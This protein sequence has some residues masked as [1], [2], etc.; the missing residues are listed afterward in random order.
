VGDPLRGYHVGWQ[1]E[2][3]EQDPL[4]GYSADW[5]TKKPVAPVAALRP[6]TTPIPP[7][8]EADFQA[9]ARQNQ[10][11]DLDHP[12]SHYDYRGAFLAGVSRGP[13]GHWPD[14]FKQHG[15]PTFSIE[16]QYAR[17]P[18]DAGH[19][20]GHRFVPAPA[21][22]TPRVRP[23]FPEYAEPPRYDP[24]TSEPLNEAARE[25]ELEEGAAR[26][27]AGE[28]G[29]QQ[30]RLDIESPRTRALGFGL[31]IG[32]GIAA[33][34]ALPFQAIKAV[35]ADLT[36]EE[37][38]NPLTLA[39]ATRYGPAAVEYV[40]SVAAQSQAP[41]PT[42]TEAFVQG[43]NPLPFLQRIGM[44][45][46]EALG[47]LGGMYLGGRAAGEAMRPRTGQE[48]VRG[49]EATAGAQ[50]AFRDLGLD[51]AT[52]TVDDVK[53]AFR[54]AA[55]RSH[56]DV[57]PA[58][59]TTHGGSAD[60]IVAV[61]EFVRLQAARDA[62]LE[63]LGQGPPAQA[64][65]PAP[66]AS[67]QPPEAKPTPP[68]APEQ[69]AVA[70]EERA[71]RGRRTKVPEGGPAPTA[72]P[73]APAAPAVVAPP[74]PI[75]RP[76]T[77]APEPPVPDLRAIENE[78]AQL[79]ALA[80]RTPEQNT[81]LQQLG[82]VLQ[83]QGTMMEPPPP[84]E[85]SGAGPAAR[86]PPVERRVEEYPVEIERRRAVAARGEAAAPAPAPGGAQ[87]GPIAPPAAPQEEEISRETAEP[88]YIPAGVQP[89]EGG[90]V[91]PAPRG[92]PAGKPARPLP[93]APT[94]RPAP[95][96][97]VER[98]AGG[99]AGPPE[100]SGLPAEAR[101]LPAIPA[102]EPAPI[103]E[104]PRGPGEGVGAARPG[105]GAVEGGPALHGERGPGRGSPYRIT[106]ADRLGAG[107]LLTKARDNVAAVRLLKQLA[108]EGRQ[109]SPEEQA[110]LVKYV[111]WGALPQAFNVSHAELGEVARELKDLLTP[112]EYE[113]A[114]A[115]TPNAHYT[116][117]VVVRSIY[118]GL[119]RMGLPTESRLLEPSA[120]V[121]HF[122]G[123]G[124][125]R[126]R[127]T[128]V[129]LDPT[130]VGILKQLYP[131]ADVR[132]GGFEEQALPQ[133]FYHAA[134][135]NVPFGDYSVH[136]PAYNKYA[137]PIHNYFVA[138]ML[139]H[140]RPGGVVAV[141]T[142]RYAMDSGKHTNWRRYI[143]DRADLLGAVRLPN[144]AFKANA[145]TEVVADILFLRR[146][147]EGER[148]AGESWV[149]SVPRDVGGVTVPRS[150]Y[151]SEHPEMVLGTEA[152]TGTQYRGEEYTVEPR[153]GED[154]AAAMKQAI[155]N[156]PE[157]VIDALPPQPTDQATARIASEEVGYR[158]EGGELQLHGQPV[159]GARVGQLKAMVRVRD[160]ARE[161]LRTQ[162]ED[163]PDASQV[164]ARK[165]LAAAYDP[166][167]RKYGPLN[168]TVK[169]GAGL[170][171]PNLEVFAEDPDV[172]LLAA[173][174][175]VNEEAGTYPKAAI[176]TERVIEKQPPIKADTPN[177]AL[178][179]VLNER[180]RV[181]MDRISDLLHQ[182]AEQVRE[183]LRGLIYEDPAGG[184]ETAD[185]YLSGNVRAKLKAAQAA[186]K[187]DPR[188]QENVKAL[189]Q[190]QPEDVPPSQIAASPG[191][192]WVPAD[193][194]VDFVEETLG[195][196]QYG[197]RVRVAYLP[198][199]AAWSVEAPYEVANSVV[200]RKEWGTQR[201]SAVRLIED[202]LNQ[203]AT[204][205]YDPGPEP[206][207]RIL[208]EKETIAARELQ[209][210]LRERF[211]E[212]VWKD[213]IRGKRLHRV[214]NDTYNNF[215]PARFDGSYL[216]L[217]GSSSAIKLLPHQKDAIWRGLQ[218][219]K[220]GLFQ[221]VGAGK[222]YEMAAM[223]M[224]AKRLGLTHKAMHVVP[225]HLVGQFQR[226][227]LK[228]YPAARLLVADD[229]TFAK[230]GAAARKEFTA[231]AATGN[232]DSIVITHSSF[233]RIPMSKQF[234]TG[235]IKEMLGQYVEAAREAKEGR[236]RDLTKL[237]EKG[238]KRLQARLKQ[239]ENREAKDDLLSF[240]HL[241]VDYLF[242]D[243]A[244][245][246]KNLYFMTKM[247]NV[248][249]AGQ[250]TQRSMDMY[251][252]SRYLDQ[253]G[254][255]L[256]LST[257]TP[258]SN[259]IS[260]MFTM[261]RY[262][263]PELLRERGIEHFDAWAA[264]F[265]EARTA[266]ELAPSGGGYRMNTRFAYFKN[267]GELAQLFRAMADVKL[268]EDLNLPIPKLR[269][270]KPQPVVVPGRPELK[271]YIEALVKRAAAI[272]ARQ[273]DPT[274]DNMLKITHDG[275]FAALDM[276][277]VDP[278]LDEGP[279]SKIAAV[280]E[281]VHRIW[282]EHAKDRATQLIFL[283]AVRPG[284]E[285]LDVYGE[286][287]RA[288]IARGIPAEEIAYVHDADTD[289]R[290]ETLFRRVREGRVR[291]MMGSIQKMG[292]GTN[293]QD[294]LLALH[295]VDAP[296]RP[297]DIEQ[298][299]GRILRRGNT[300][301][302]V[303]IYH[304]VTEGS[305]DSYIWQ[306]LERK[307]RSSDQMMKAEA[308]TRTI[309]DV[310][311]RALTFAE[312]KAISTGNP[313]VME[314]ASVDAEIQRLNRLA[315]S[316][317]D[318]QFQIRQDLAGM[319]DRQ[320]GLEKYI[321]NVAADQAKL[322]DVAGKAFTVKLGDQTFVGRPE[323]GA[324][325]VDL[326]GKLAAG[327]PT[328][329]VRLG[330]YAGLDLMFTM[331]FGHPQMML[332]G[333]QSY[334]TPMPETVQGVVQALEY[335]PKRLSI[336][337]QNAIDRLAN[338]QKQAA[339]LARLKDE[340]FAQAEALAKLA[341]RQEE[342]NRQLDL[343][344][345]EANEVAEEAGIPE[346]GTQDAEDGPAVVDLEDALAEAAGTPEGEPPAA[347][348]PAMNQSLR[349]Q[350]VD[351]LKLSH[352]DAERLSDSDVARE[353]VKQGILDD[354]T[355]RDLV[356]NV[357]RWISES[358]AGLSQREMDDA[359]VDAELRKADVDGT[360]H[361][362]AEKQ[363]EGLGFIS[364][365]FLPPSWAM[366]RLTY[367]KNPDTAAA[368]RIGERM[369]DLGRNAHLALSRYADQREALVRQTEKA[370]DKRELEHLDRL[371]RTVARTEELPPGT[372]AK[373]AAAHGAWRR[374][375]LEDKR[376]MGKMRQLVLRGRSK[377]ILETALA[378]WP[379]GMPAPDFD[380][381][382]VNRRRLLDVADDH[383][384][385]SN[386]TTREQW[387][388]LYEQLNAE[389]AR[390]AKPAYMESPDLRATFAYLRGEGGIDAYAPE[391]HL[392]D[393]KVRAGPL[394]KRFTDRIDALDY[395]RLLLES[396]QYHEDITIVRDAYL[397]DYGVHLSRKA[398]MAMRSKL[399]QVAGEESAQVAMQAGKVRIRPR[400]RFF[401]HGQHRAVHLETYE[402]DF[403]KYIRTY[404]WRLA[405]YL[406]F[407]PFRHAATD[408]LETL[409]YDG[410]WRDWA[411]AY[412]AGVQGVPGELTT[413]INNTLTH[414]LRGYGGPIPLQTG[415]GMWQR[416]VSFWLGG[417]N[418]VWPVLH[419]I[420]YMTN[421]PSAFEQD[422]HK[423]AWRG[424]TEL[425]KG[426]P[427]STA[428]I[429]AAGIRFQH[430]SYAVSEYL[431]RGVGGKGE[432][433][434]HPMWMF[435]TALDAMRSAT[436]LAKYYEQRAAGRAVADAQA[437]ATRFVRDT[438][439][440]FSM[441]DAPRVMRNP[442][443]RVLGQLQLYGLNQL[444]FAEDVF[445]R[446]NYRQ[447][448]AFTFQTW[449]WIGA[450]GLM[451]T[452]P[453]FVLNWI[454]G[455]TG[456]FRDRN[457]RKDTPWGALWDH[458]GPANATR[459]LAAF[460][461]GILGLFGINLSEHIGMTGPSG[462]RMPVPAGLIKKAADALTA[463]DPRR[464][465]AAARQLQPV[466]VQRLQRAWAAAHEHVIRDS[467]GR[468]IQDT[469]TAGDPLRLAAG[470]QSITQ[471]ER[472]DQID[473]ERE[474]IADY[475]DARIGWLEQVKAA[476]E[477]GGWDAASAVL[478]E[479][480]RDS[481]FLTGQDVRTYIRRGEE[482]EA[483]RRRR[484][485]PP[486]LRPSFGMPGM[487]RRRTRIP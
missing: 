68:G 269:G 37:A 21:R 122:L 74:S 296:W 43:L 319:P 86:Q 443:G 444:L 82:V 356:E 215:R 424:L 477:Q 360:P 248:P 253:S 173:L 418:P 460:K 453:L 282:Q 351:A 115:S 348:S 208:N 445:R 273:V 121:G 13:E 318:R 53:A 404:N 447:K 328:Q 219:R 111:G 129:E 479:A 346:E 352:A 484:A 441:A 131:N 309:E 112:D 186:A 164:Q 322:V 143:A 59:R 452:W 249:G 85:E 98:G 136:D 317:R 298:G 310:D 405:R 84:L 142:S 160:A 458:L 295:H 211:A 283:N 277:L 359:E 379:E 39:A 78:A 403:S 402:K 239:I 397:P 229:R 414:L 106:A 297:A 23:R 417:Y 465:A 308:S 28:R 340:P 9:W 191:A 343:D 265:G 114:R 38:R 132:A 27:Y 439:F 147:L 57:D 412:V 382:P 49:P 280:A 55:K 218:Q 124:P 365:Y 483:E 276:R 206:G 263:Q 368:A 174:E 342:L 152:M 333:E 217:P 72:A 17:G 176:F 61:Q 118:D 204:T 91:P 475:R 188:F 438:Y 455:K 384:I 148:P 183:A 178:L 163:E 457:G 416:L 463:A 470:F 247:R 415:A 480:R 12:D 485:T 482:S 180:G 221:V 90:A 150:E 184:L 406:A 377:A 241:G 287:K 228:L 1:D 15:H 350:L 419:T 155:A 467:Y 250:L 162:A 230:A 156:L 231:R 56:P 109:A 400:S 389:K 181:D 79:S 153:E 294:R 50:Q 456:W 201:V 252:K 306:M 225:N 398:W 422:G 4:A 399:A 427:E 44:R 388:A 435:N 436:A 372:P 394:T 371:L 281:Q 205:V 305:F 411:E 182:P 126:A 256:V 80:T 116:S 198:V 407:Q 47:Q 466:I 65:R 401:A 327:D 105:A 246:Y 220:L 469:T 236:N 461:Y 291:V 268:A 392:G 67:P 185:N 330:K 472:Q 380:T 159:T 243:E 464:R 262:L 313:L 232:W 88:P 446:G 353:A 73:G 284:F 354:V 64:A 476:Y 161:V 325:L 383:G 451:A 437:A 421:V 448:A 425:V 478:E 278:M 264:A 8:R 363:P 307:A 29:R 311:G 395:A 81:R 170:R 409:P 369:V 259:T 92:E 214:Y 429:D 304:Y 224:E 222:T 3:E 89:P 303:Q 107:G 226:D 87:E 154:L 355:Q 171:R 423:W 386:P 194:V 223:A 134:I 48:I 212:W 32:K 487:P 370:L 24:H 145:G 130:T 374:Q 393:W 19:W 135:T 96:A 138:K 345:S 196:G 376:L 290:K 70:T 199:E 42:E 97:P 146:R 344:K 102:R 62:A 459:S 101:P 361:I 396:G 137:F 167:A 321:A 113:K 157:D 300:H 103:R 7:E 66:A 323:A 133:A 454:V 274:V 18:E 267:V 378:E 20:E 367:S 238:K 94:E 128:A 16:S 6:E 426:S 30:L 449:A 172:S 373:V 428:A 440:D 302:E 200:A 320:A 242:A 430:P 462:W 213:E 35:F 261:Q 473:R 125:A 326:R 234:E 335:L 179:A 257:G 110:Q 362:Y 207:Q 151:F 315:S 314:K 299:D 341:R 432:A 209:Q 387:Q 139:D 144:T 385:S 63:A 349:E 11:T 34:A 202:A 166:M 260:E 390:V 177:D 60:P 14:T 77:P 244:Q 36:P 25:A 329:V 245:A 71:Y 31:G 251:L 336:E 117:E 123:L 168:K 434:W 83:E 51:P 149:N 375:F 192:P 258:I 271:A 233:A 119:D 292:M 190:V 237:I 442:A 195:K 266:L 95:A 301:P 40:R 2:P 391:V 54:E 468:I 227:F 289:L 22:R 175:D 338:F 45:D 100:P 141:I 187:A 474:V 165:K 420:Q 364:N 33:V 486:A 255:R 210:K 108:G 366:N 193:D 140:V 285:K 104:Q 26:T 76:V 334:A 450:A 481:I 279:H 99:G 324:R 316:H 254:G 288:M 235:F 93:G 337:R 216:T 339:D 332:Q 293:V 357:R 272:K 189:E 58:V 240:E 312:I 10:I 127:W 331:S 46:P 5:R 275:R 158:L 75:S 69:P 347:L 41:G 169:S 410:G 120:G 413:S 471:A 381:T 431:P 358:G 52:A 408:L 286:V 197:R 203:I 270:G 433:W